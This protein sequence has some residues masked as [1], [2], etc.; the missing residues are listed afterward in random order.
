MIQTPAMTRRHWIIAASILAIGIVV[1]LL[2]GW[3]IGRQYGIIPPAPVEVRKNTTPQYPLINPLIFTDSDQRLFPEYSRLDDQINSYVSNAIS[4]GN[5]TSISV[6][7]RN[8]NTGHWTGTNID[9]KYEPSSMLKVA[10]LIATLRAAL[11]Q[12]S[13]TI[14]SIDTEL[15][16]SVYYPGTDTSGLNYPPAHRLAAG[17]YTEKDLLN[18]MIVDSD[19]VAAT[20][21][22]GANSDDFQSTYNDF[23]L[24][25]TPAGAVTDFMTAK[26]YSVIFRALYNAGYLTRNLSEMAL[27]LLSRT[28][29]T[30]GIVS[31]IPSGITVAHKFG[32]HT[33][34]LSD[35][36]PIGHELHDCG[37]VYASEE[38]YLI[39]IMTKGQD[40]SSLEGVI[41]GLSKLVYNYVITNEMGT[42]S[43]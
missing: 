27:E 36:T 21:L 9:E 40:F 13:M 29:F 38:P 12:S 28:S 41:S 34:E 16:K 3:V 37:I 18:A 1:G 19:N 35:G 17:S 4:S 2:C 30:Q 10:V 43:D 24:P 20:V 22:L 25:P 26:S 11:T 6:Y 42:H 23:R 39:C 7:Y 31:G 15:S 14:S 33:Y 5:A 32:E 8:L